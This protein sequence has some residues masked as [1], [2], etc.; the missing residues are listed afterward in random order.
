[1]DRRAIICCKLLLFEFC[2]G[3]KLLKRTFS[4]QADTRENLENVN[5]MQ[6]YRYRYN[7]MFLQHAGLASEETAERLGVLGS[8]LRTM[9]PD[10]ITES[11]SPCPN[12]VHVLVV[13]FN[14]EI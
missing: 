10:T 3:N 5:N 9:I 4:L 6:L 14:V 13:I 7:K 12:V 8:D 1:M 11:V 2:R